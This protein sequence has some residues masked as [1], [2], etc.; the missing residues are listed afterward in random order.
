MSFINSSARLIAVAAFAA[1]G[2]TYADGPYDDHLDEV[3]AILHEMGFGNDG[4]I[5]VGFLHDT[6]EDTQITAGD[7]RRFGVP[8]HIIQSVLFVTDEPGHNRK[9][10][11]ANTYVRVTNDLGRATAGTPARAPTPEVV[12]G[13]VV[14][15]ADRIANL[16]SS[17][18]GNPG[19]L[20]MYRKEAEMFRMIYSPPPAVQ[21]TFPAAWGRLLTEYDRLVG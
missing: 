12:V 13:L 3:V 14:K 2:K 8:E 15:W 18:R 11:K 21:A 5:Q 20:K 7:F 4:Y 19:L 16:R 1:I 17:H 6:L 10:R 9:T